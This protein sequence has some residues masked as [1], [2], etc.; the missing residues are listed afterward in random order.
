MKPLLEQMITLKVAPR[1]AAHVALLIQPCNV[2]PNTA[3]GGKRMP[4]VQHALNPMMAL[5]K[6]KAMAAKEKR[7]EQLLLLQPLL[8]SALY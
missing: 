2:M 5:A 7:Q 6:A 1:M 8:L 3:A 4:M